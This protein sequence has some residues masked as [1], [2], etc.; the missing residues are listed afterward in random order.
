LEVLGGGDIAHFLL[1][2]VQCSIFD[3]LPC[4][5]EYERRDLGFGDVYHS[6]LPV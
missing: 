6:Y 5:W 1:F 3:A 2:A 4:L